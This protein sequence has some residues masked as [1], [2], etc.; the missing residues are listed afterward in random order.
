MRGKRLE[1]L[2]KTGDKLRLYFNARNKA[3]MLSGREHIGFAEAE[4]GT[5]GKDA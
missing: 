1:H 4:L 3:Y 5:R 2:V